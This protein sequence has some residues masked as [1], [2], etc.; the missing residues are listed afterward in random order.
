MTLME[1]CSGNICD[2]DEYNGQPLWKANRVDVML[3]KLKNFPDVK[4][5]HYFIVDNEVY[6]IIGDKENYEKIAECKKNH[7]EPTTGIRKD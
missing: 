5:G 6:L 4:K 3:S 2:L 1:S 7:V